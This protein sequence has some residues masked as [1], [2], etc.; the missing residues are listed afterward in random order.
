M[1]SSIIPLYPFGEHWWWSIWINLVRTE[2]MKAEML[3]E[4]ASQ[5][6]QRQQESK[7]S[8]HTITFQS[9]WNYVKSDTTKWL[10]ESNEKKPVRRIKWRPWTDGFIH[11]STEWPETW[12]VVGIFHCVCVCVLSRPR[13]MKRTAAMAD[14]QLKNMCA[15]LC[16]CHLIL[17][18]SCR[19]SDVFSIYIVGLLLFSENYTALAKNHIVPLWNCGC[20]QWALIPFFP[21]TAT[22]MA[23]WA[24]IFP[25]RLSHLILSHSYATR[26]AHTHI[27][28]RM[29]LNWFNW[30]L[31]TKNETIAGVWIEW[32]GTKWLV[33]HPREREKEIIQIHEI[34]TNWDMYL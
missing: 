15:H 30:T 3:V 14:K 8:I 20:S 23:W 5:S 22:G 19:Q 18:H 7:K 31:D 33:Q 28:F 34:D 2:R 25:L 10:N 27:R 4:G 11:T 6:K 24:Q 26:C 13:S 9:M 1:C 32:N 16:V 29:Y 21:A 17:A 12:A